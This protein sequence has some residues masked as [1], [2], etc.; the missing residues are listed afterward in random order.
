MANVQY[1]LSTRVVNGQAEVLIRFYASRVLDQRAHTRVHVPVH[2]WSE[3]KQRL[4]TSTRYVTP[5]TAT[6]AELQAKLDTLEQVVLSRYIHDQYATYKGWLQR[7]VDEAMIPQALGITSEPLTAAQACLDYIE[8][9]QLA[10]T[11]R[12][13]YEFL[14]KTFNHFAERYRTIYMNTLSV[15]DIED[16]QRFLYTERAE[17]RSRNTVVSRLRKF[18][19]VCYWEVRKGVLNKCPFGDNGF[20]LEQE[21]Y[22]TP[23]T[24]S[25]DEI[26][27]VYRASMPTQRMAEQRD[28]FVFQCYVGQRIS[29]LQRMTDANIIEQADGKTLQYIQHKT[30]KTNPHITS[31]PLS[32]TAVEILDRYHGKQPDGRILPFIAEQNYNYAIK[33]I[34]REAGITRLVSV[35]NTHTFEEESKPICDIASSHLAR[36]SFISNVYEVTQEERLTISLSGHAEGSRALDRYIHIKQS[37][38]RAVI[39][40]LNRGGRQ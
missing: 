35:L 36:R 23:T 10:G 22:G 30:N 40:K 1:R 7:V 21:V 37:T 13:H 17:G 28:I 20:K 15:Q 9:K 8:Y 6:A 5:E 4:N 32:D 18:R 24:L 11:T 27:Q 25:M 12:A 31:V 14:A 26:E 39:D 16:L 33:D 3:K 34:L 29:D 38:K 2:L 19:A